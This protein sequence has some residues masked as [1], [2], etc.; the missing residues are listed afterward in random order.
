MGKRWQAIE[1]QGFR[2]YD[3]VY[4][5]PQWLE[6]VIFGLEN[7]GKQVKKLRVRTD[8]PGLR[9]YAIFTKEV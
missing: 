1:G 5:D 4:S 8:T 9:V 2:F 7:Q 3:Y 6:S